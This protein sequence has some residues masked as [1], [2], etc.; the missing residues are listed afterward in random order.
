MLE[1][2]R[3]EKILYNVIYMLYMLLYIRDNVVAN[4]NEMAVD[5][6]RPPFIVLM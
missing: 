6:V 5:C 3:G 2:K 4:K 1:G